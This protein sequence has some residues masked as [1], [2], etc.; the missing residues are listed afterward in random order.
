MDF[1]FY[2]QQGVLGSLPEDKRNYVPIDNNFEIGDLPVKLELRYAIEAKR[3]EKGLDMPVIE[4]LPR[5][6]REL[7]MEEEERRRVRRER[8]KVAA[9]R[10]RVKRKSHVTKLIEETDDLH[11][12]NNQLENIIERLELEKH[13]LEEA[14]RLHSCKS[15]KLCGYD[16]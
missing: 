7:T 2:S 16:K 6:S 15:I 11:K 8:N 4:K 9:L 1:S 3:A 10:C 13:K 14:I 12:A 5:V